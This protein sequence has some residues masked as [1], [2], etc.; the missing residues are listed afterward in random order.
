M[1]VI[2]HALVG[3]GTGLSTLSARQPQQ[4]SQS[5][6]SGRDYWI[7]VTI[8]LAYLPDIAAQ[9]LH[10]AGISDVLHVSRLTHS[11]GFAMLAAPVAGWLIAR[12]GLARFTAATA[13]AFVSVMLHVL[14]DLLQ[15]TDRAVLWPLSGRL[16]N[17]GVAVLPTS[18]P[19]E[20]GVLSVLVAAGALV[21]RARGVRMRPSRL[22]LL[23]V[24][25]VGLVLALAI[26]THV[27]RDRRERQLR[28]AK[29]LAEGQHSYALSLQIL[30]EA[31]KWPA[32]AK[33]GR[34][35][36]LR[37]ECFDRL[38]DRARAEQYYLKS[39]AAD[40]AYFWVVADL[41]IFYASGPQPEAARRQASAPYV[42][43]LTADFARHP[44]LPSTLDRVRRKLAAVPA[45]D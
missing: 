45:P 33:P 22:H 21:A 42:E 2:G 19:G 43:R 11:I 1:P 32:P 44:E 28:I 24:V 34:I 18:L 30:D 7:L 29:W 39:Y 10:A 27:L 3:L 5:A 12:A 4:E 9:S 37:A 35:D 26:T 8:V 16:A 6:D 25:C 31:A 13:V 36:Y 38:G 14:L 17:L 41:A 40:P 15:G 23:P 20:V